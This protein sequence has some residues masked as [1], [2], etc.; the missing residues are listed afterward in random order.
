[1][2]PTGSY[3]LV[4]CAPND[5]EYFYFNVVSDNTTQAAFQ[6]KI[7]TTSAQGDIIL[8]IL[9][10]SGATKYGWYF[11][12]PLAQDSRTLES[13]GYYF[14]FYINYHNV[15]YAFDYEITGFQ[16]PITSGSFTSASITTNAITS[17]TNSLILI[18]RNY[19]SS[20]FT[21][22]WTLNWKFKCRNYWS[23]TK[24]RGKFW[25]LSFYY[26]TCDLLLIDLTTLWAKT[27][28]KN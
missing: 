21:H 2:Q 1:M 25:N 11:A 18:L 3:N 16:R 8:R 7:N 5:Y 13:G 22:N 4:F 9:D 23:S 24:F 14:L 26:F 17:G 10:E 12:P 19:C 15:S 6:F 27:D 20:K 28:S